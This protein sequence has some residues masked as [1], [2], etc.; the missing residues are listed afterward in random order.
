MEWWVT[1]G[2]VDCWV[3]GLTHRAM[4]TH[5]LTDALQVGDNEPRLKRLSKLLGSGVQGGGLMPL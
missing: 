1:R 5:F 4:G 2:L 3:M